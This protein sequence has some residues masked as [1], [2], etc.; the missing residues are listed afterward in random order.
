MFPFWLDFSGIS[1]LP[2]AAVIA[3]VSMFL[4]SGSGRSYGG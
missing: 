3:V 1:T 4:M 2:V